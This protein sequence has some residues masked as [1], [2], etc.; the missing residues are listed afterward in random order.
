MQQPR[1]GAVAE[2]KSDQGRR[3]RQTLVSPSSDSA[4]SLSLKEQACLLAGLDTARDRV[5][6][7]QQ[8]A[9]WCLELQARLQ[10]AEEHLLHDDCRRHHRSLASEIERLKLCISLAKKARAAS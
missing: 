6:V 8:I 5:A 4:S 9:D 10:R 3:H 7:D 2:V 1:N